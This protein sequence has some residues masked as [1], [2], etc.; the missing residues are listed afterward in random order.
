MSQDRDQMHLAPKF[1][2][3]YAKAL[4]EFNA[5]LSVHRPG[6]SAKLIEGFRSAAYQHE[7]YLKKPR[8]T[9]KDGYINRSNHQSG[10]AADVGVFQGAKY[11]EEPD[12]ETMAFYGHCVRAAG[13]TWGGDW[14]SFVDKP[15]AEWPTSDPKAYH[16]AAVWLKQSGLA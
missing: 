1:R 3:A 15:H 12:K 10:M 7:L 9:Y 16:E 4:S 5:W 14:S 13:L 8:V 6:L 11:I 2:A